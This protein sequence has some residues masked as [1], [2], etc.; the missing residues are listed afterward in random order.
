MTEKWTANYCVLRCSGEENQ[1]IA[2]LKELVFLR[3]SLTEFSFILSSFVQHVRMSVR[4]CLVVATIYAKI[5]THQNCQLLTEDR[6]EE[7]Q[8]DIVANNAH[9][10]RD[11]YAPLEAIYLEVNQTHCGR[12][13]HAT[14]GKAPNIPPRFH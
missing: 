9:P 14:P 5:T 12:S 6:F 1:I 3:V 7:I 13:F 4:L 11:L 10:A 2:K 8:L